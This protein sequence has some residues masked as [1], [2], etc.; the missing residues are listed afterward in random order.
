MKT[1]RLKSSYQFTTTEFIAKSKSRQEFVPLVGPL[2]DKAHVE[3]L[4]VKNNA[5]QYSFRCLLK[6]AIG[7]DFCRGSKGHLFCK[8]CY[9]TSV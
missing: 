3:P 5:W 6:E 9:C 4:H 8:S 1:K 2:I 7:K